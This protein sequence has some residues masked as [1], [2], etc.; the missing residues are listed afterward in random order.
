MAV[1][2]FH[3]IGPLGYGVLMPVHDAKKLLLDLRLGKSCVLIEFIVTSIVA[4]KVAVV[5]V[6]VP[7]EHIG[8]IPGSGIGIPKSVDVVMGD[9]PAV[10]V[11]ELVEFLVHQRHVAGFDNP[12]EIIHY[13]KITDGCSS[14]CLA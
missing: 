10:E 3:A 4:A 6:E 7:N 1:V 12:P 2:P 11:Q 9:E 14:C 8:K 13:R 5:S